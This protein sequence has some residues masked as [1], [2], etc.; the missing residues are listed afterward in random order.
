[1]LQGPSGQLKPIPPEDDVLPRRA[2][3]KEPTVGL[4]GVG[5]ADLALAIRLQDAEVDPLRAQAQRNGF[6]GQGAATR[7]IPPRYCSHPA[8][9][10][11]LSGPS[12]GQESAE[13]GKVSGHHKAHWLH[14]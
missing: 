3:S 2:R 5:D 4:A 7:H 10:A 12:R 8:I 6:S 14:D 1:M 13:S 11:M 9:S